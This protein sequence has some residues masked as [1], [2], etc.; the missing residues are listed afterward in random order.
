MTKD[1]LKENLILARK[2]YSMCVILYV[3]Y[4]CTY[5]H[6]YIKN[7]RNKQQN[8]ELLCNKFKNMLEK[9]PPANLKISQ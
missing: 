1:I 2:I 3:C 8:Q 9:Y 7:I 6:M 4:T 5:T